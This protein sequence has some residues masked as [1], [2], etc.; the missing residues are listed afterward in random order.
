MPCITGQHLLFSHNHYLFLNL[1][2]TISQQNEK[3][4]TP[5]AKQKKPSAPKL[6]KKTTGSQKR[7]TSDHCTPSSAKKRKSGVGRKNLKSK[8]TAKSADDNFDITEVAEEGDE[9]GTK[10]K[11]NISTDDIV[12][13]LPT[14]LKHPEVVFIPMFGSKEKDMRLPITDISKYFVWIHSTYTC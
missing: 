9:F 8:P 10:T 5:A 6:Q 3:K 4:K 7:K 11:S 2:G 13:T 12:P 14:K 1:G